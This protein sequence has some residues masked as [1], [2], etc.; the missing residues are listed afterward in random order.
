MI[1]SHPKP[2][3]PLRIAIL[4]SCSCCRPG[5]KLFS[6][7]F[8]S[9]YLSLEQAAVDTLLWM[10]HLYYPQDERNETYT[11][12][13]N[14]GSPVQYDHF[15]SREYG[16]PFLFSRH[17]LNFGTNN[18][19]HRQFS[20]RRPF[21]VLS[22]ST[23]GKRR[24]AEEVLRAIHTQNVN[25]HLNIGIEYDFFGTKGAYRHQ[26]TR[27]NSISLFQSITRATCR[28]KARYLAVI[29]KIRRMVV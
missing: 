12:L 14:L 3:R 24:E 7:R 15:F 19:S 29:S 27:D 28:C 6:W 23:G 20:V 26:E 10:N 1:H 5:K 8:N 13:G 4:G 21:T 16:K 25:Q 17:Y 2:T 9:T 11:F 18:L 22:Y